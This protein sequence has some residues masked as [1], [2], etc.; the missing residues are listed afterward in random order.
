MRYK[1]LIIFTFLFAAYL[2]KGQEKKVDA[3]PHQGLLTKGLFLK[4][5]DVLIPW[6]IPLK[7]LADIGDPKLIEIN[8][9]RTLLIW[10]SAQI[11]NG[12]KVELK[13]FMNQPSKQLRYL[14]AQIPVEQFKA[15]Q[16]FLDNYTGTPATIHYMTKHDYY[17]RWAVD[18]CNLRLAFDRK[19][20]S[21]LSIERRL[22][23]M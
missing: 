20:G 9:R 13:A 1:F 7:D 17:Y 2:S 6:G 18:D 8:K 14:Y 19:N 5:K 16:S 12:F 23:G 3:K 22:N 15:L 10:D 11:L 21:H 4:N